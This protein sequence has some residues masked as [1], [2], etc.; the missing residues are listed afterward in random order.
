MIPDLFLNA[1]VSTFIHIAASISNALYHLLILF[2]RLTPSNI[3]AFWVYD[4]FSQKLYLTMWKDSY[5]IV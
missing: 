5:L 4:P 2:I 3:L 1:S